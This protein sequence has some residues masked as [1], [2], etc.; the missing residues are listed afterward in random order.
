MGKE[1]D[2]IAKLKLQYQQ[3]HDLIDVDAQSSNYFDALSTTDAS[4]NLLQEKSSMADMLDNYLKDKRNEHE[5][6]NDEKE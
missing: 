3:K 5:Q 6:E 2:S 1:L 4:I